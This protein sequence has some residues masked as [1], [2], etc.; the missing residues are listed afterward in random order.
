M[1]EY[2]TLK[3]LAKIARKDYPDAAYITQNK[4]GEWYASVLKPTF[5][6]NWSSDLWVSESEPP[7]DAESELHSIKM[8]MEDLYIKPMSSGASYRFS[9]GHKTVV[10]DDTWCPMKQQG[11]L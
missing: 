8:L 5:N 1:T 2:S 10:Y 9:Y 11:A 6:E 7:I 4:N 3:V